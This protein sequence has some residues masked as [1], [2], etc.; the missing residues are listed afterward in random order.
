MTPSP[1]CNQTDDE[2]KAWLKANVRV[3]ECV[4]VR[5][6]QAGILR[7]HLATVTKVGK[8]RFEVDSLGKG[9]MSNAGAS[10]YFSGKNCRHPQGQTHVVIPTDE[11]KQFHENKLPGVHRYKLTS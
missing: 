2:I 11:V 4:A 5:H 3:G 9:L 1:C 10:F 8:D 7:Y 6:T